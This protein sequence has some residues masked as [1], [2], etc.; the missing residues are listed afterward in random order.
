M[1]FATYVTAL[2]E[3]T[4]PVGFGRRLMETGFVGIVV[5]AQGEFVTV[6]LGK[7]PWLEPLEQTHQSLGLA[8]GLPAKLSPSV[9]RKQVG[10]AKLD[11]AVALIAC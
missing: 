2:H 9:L 10:Y 7:V 6:I 11:A 5:Y 3:V 4:G 1:H 8:L